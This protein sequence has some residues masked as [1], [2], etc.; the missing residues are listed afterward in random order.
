MDV[1]CRSVETRRNGL[2]WH[3]QV[4][5]IIKCCNCDSIFINFFNSI[6]FF[7]NIPLIEV[8]AGDLLLLSRWGILQT[9]DVVDNFDL[10]VVAV[11]L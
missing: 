5:Y 8:C 1:Q 10:Y 4:F 9:P 11:T 6:L 3:Y 2:L 7:I